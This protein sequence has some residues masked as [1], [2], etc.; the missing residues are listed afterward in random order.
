[1]V[2]HKKSFFFTIEGFP[3]GNFSFIRQK[4][5][6]V[7]GELWGVCGAR[8]RA[9]QLS[10]TQGSH[11]VFYQVYSWFSLSRQLTCFAGELINCLILYVVGK[12]IFCF[13]FFSV[14]IKHISTYIRDVF[15]NN[16]DYILEIT[17]NFPIYCVTGKPI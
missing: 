10:R 15:T 14:A 1:M 12:P 4:G 8:A 9:T 11:S 6:G 17:S 7:R 16:A 3:Y 2:L 5:F 13:I